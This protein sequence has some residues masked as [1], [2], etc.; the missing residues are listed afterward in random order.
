MALFTLI[1]SPNKFSFVFPQTLSLISG[2]NTYSN[3]PQILSEKQLKKLPLFIPSFCLKQPPNSAWFQTL[4]KF[5][6]SSQRFVTYV[7]SNLPPLI[8]RTCDFK[9]PLLL[10]A[11]SC[12]CLFLIIGSVYYSPPMCLFDI[13]FHLFQVYF[14]KIL[15]CQVYIASL[16]SGIHFFL[17]ALGFFKLPPK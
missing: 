8:C 4:N 10:L 5:A 15:G 17:A 16:P 3:K 9:S 12:N 11:S 13:P 14:A 7:I 6:N 1:L 2:S